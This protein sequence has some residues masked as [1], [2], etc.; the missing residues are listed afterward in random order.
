MTDKIKQNNNN[1]TQAKK[2]TLTALSS[3][4]WMNT[5]LKGNLKRKNP[6]NYNGFTWQISFSLTKKD[7]VLRASENGGT[8]R[9][10]D[11]KNGSNWGMKEPVTGNNTEGPN[12][13]DHN[14]HYSPLMFLWSN[15]RPPSPNS[16]RLELFGLVLSARTSFWAVWPAMLSGNG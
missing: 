10:T 7:I 4:R 13:D 3:K 1:K 11:G 2:S 15:S 6:L 14:S 16:K 12:P 9:R 5:T 8:G